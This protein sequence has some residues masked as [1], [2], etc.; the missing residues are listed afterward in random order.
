M[1]RGNQTAGPAIAQRPKDRGRTRGI[2]QCLRQQVRATGL[3]V[4]AGDADDPHRRRGGTIKLV[5]QGAGLPGQIRNRDQWNGQIRQLRSPLCGIEEHGSSASPDGL[6]SIVK[7]VSGQA[8]AG[9]EQVVRLDG[10]RIERQ[11]T[12]AGIIPC[13]CRRHTPWC[14]QAIQCPV[15]RPR[16]HPSSSGLAAECT[17]PAPSGRSSGGI[18]ISRRAPAMTRAN[19]GAATAPP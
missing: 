7:A 12:D 18:S 17:R 5:R 1:A 6:L 11:T 2:V 13:R 10:A 16:A 4:G 15:H 8:G 19:T 3:A 9:E 14:Q